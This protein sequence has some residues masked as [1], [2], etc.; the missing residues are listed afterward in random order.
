MLLYSCFAFL[1][2]VTFCSDCFRKVFFLNLG[3]KKKL[4]LLALVVLYSNNCMEIC[5]GG[6]TIGRL[7]RVVVWTGLPVTTSLNTIYSTFSNNDG[8][9]LNLYQHSRN[10]FQMANFFAST[11]QTG[12]YMFKVKNRNTRKRWEICSKLT[13]KTP[14]WNQSRHFSVFIVN[15]ELI[16]HLVLVFLLLTLSR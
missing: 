2:W 5:L 6:L 9:F 12:N 14:E 7:R 1:F 4:L 3:D 10:F 8:K 13:I 11:Y 16:L 15:F